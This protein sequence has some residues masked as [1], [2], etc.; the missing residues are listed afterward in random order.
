MP[1]HNDQD[2]DSLWNSVL[3][4]WEDG[5]AHERFVQACHV[6]SRLGYA[7]AKYRSLLDDKPEFRAFSLPELDQRAGAVRKHMAAITILAS[8]ALDASR[9]E[10]RQPLQHWVLFAAA[11]LLIGALVWVAYALSR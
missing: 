1:E 9:S 11:G 6:S 2:L 3:R 8:Q 7:A 4:A 5:P 10:R